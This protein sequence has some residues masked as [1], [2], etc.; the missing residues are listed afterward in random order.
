L[1]AKDTSVTQFTKTA[2]KADFMRL[3]NSIQLSLKAETL[4][5]STTVEPFNGAATGS[6]GNRDR[7]AVDKFVASQ[8]QPYT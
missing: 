6:G 3:K 5:I 8:E 1:Y 7:L 2:D 4:L